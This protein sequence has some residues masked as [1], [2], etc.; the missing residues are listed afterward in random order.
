MSRDLTRDGEVHRACDRSAEQDDGS[1]NANR[2]A[3][4]MCLPAVPEPRRISRT[5]PDAHATSRESPGHAIRARLRLRL[6]TPAGREV[7]G[8]PFLPDSHALPW[9]DSV[10]SRPRHSDSDPSGP[11]L[12]MEQPQLG[13]HSLPLSEISEGAAVIFH[14]LF[15]QGD[16][17]SDFHRSR[18]QTTVAPANFRGR[19]SRRGVIRILSTMIPCK[20]LRTNE[21][22]G[23]EA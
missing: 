4:A 15:Y 2:R 13:L 12:G 8:G 23:N 9:D 22:A 20:P 18:F 19:E 3:Q 11:P 21:S 10:R 7:S 17:G 6:A 16:R 1:M 14:L 5:M